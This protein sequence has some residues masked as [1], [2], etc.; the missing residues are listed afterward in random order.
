MAR[1]GAPGV[2]PVLNIPATGRCQCGACEYRL[3]APPFVSYTCHCRACQALSASAFNTCIQVPAEAVTATLGAP[4]ERQRTADSGNVLTTWFCGRCGSAL[5]AQNSA[6]PRIRTIYVGTLDE[7][8]DVEVNAH[9]WT[10][11]KLPWVILPEAHREFRRGGDWREDYAGEL[12][13]YL[14]ET[15]S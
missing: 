7:R 9:I 4:L 5:F 6:R 14:P 15:R 13:R 8:Q 10:E 11:A 12:D 1:H 3:E 2:T